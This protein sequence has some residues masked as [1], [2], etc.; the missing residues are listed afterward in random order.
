MPS[1]LKTIFTYLHDYSLTEAQVLLY[2]SEKNGLITRFF[3]MFF[4]EGKVK[5]AAEIMSQVKNLQHTPALV[6]TFAI[7]LFL[8]EMHE[9]EGDKSIL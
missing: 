6:R 9:W 3:C 8:L 4:F 2:I 5:E 1:T 7:A